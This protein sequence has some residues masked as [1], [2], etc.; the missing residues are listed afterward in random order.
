MFFEQYSHEPFLAVA[1][2]WL[3]ISDL[4]LYA[5]THVAEQS[6]FDLGGYPAVVLARARSRRAWARHHHR[7]ERHSSPAPWGALPACFREPDGAG[8]VGPSV[9]AAWGLLLSPAFARRSIRTLIVP[10]VT[11]IAGAISLS[12]RS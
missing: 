4:A 6:G 2:Y 1:R 5:Y 7:V 12:V 11:P 3:T 10:E 8:F 9:G